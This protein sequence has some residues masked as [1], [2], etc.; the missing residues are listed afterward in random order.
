[1]AKSLDTLIDVEGWAMVRSPMVYS[2]KPEEIVNYYPTDIRTKQM[3]DDFGIPVPAELEYSSM[4]KYAVLTGRPMYGTPRYIALPQ[5]GQTQCTKQEVIPIPAPK[6]R[7][8][9]EV[10][11]YNGKWQKYLKSSGWVAA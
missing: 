9:I 7:K 11:W 6:V 3:T 8:G 10:R 2:D 4:G 1:M 5:L